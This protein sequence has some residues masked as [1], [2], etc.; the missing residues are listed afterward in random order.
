MNP[1][2]SDS[3]SA[4]AKLSTEQRVA[5]E[6][7]GQDV[8]VVAGPGS[9]KTRVLTER[10]AWLVEAREVN[11]ARILAITFTEK[12]AIEIKRR[13]VARFADRSEFRESIERAWVSTIDGFCARI[14]RENAIAAGLSPEF[15]I[16]EAA[17]AK[18]LQR[19]AGEEALD[20]LLQERPVEFRRLLEAL[21]LSTQD[22]GRQ[23]DLCASLL[24]VYETMRTSGGV[25][26]P[27]A[28]ASEDVWPAVRAM[29]GTILADATA[30]NT[31]N[32][33]AA[34]A[35]VRE[36]AQAMLGLSG[37]PVANRHFECLSLARGIN[38][39]HLMT[40]SPARESFKTLKDD[41]NPQLESQWISLRYADLHD[42]L[43][44]ALKRMD[45][46]YRARKRQQG[47]LD[48]GDL[49]EFTI[50]L[51]E[52]NESI[53]SEVAARFDQVLMDE[54]QDTNRT[55]WRLIK[56]L[57]NTDAK[58]YAVGDIN[59][60]IYG[61]RNADPEV[62]A[63]YRNQLRISGAVIDELA[64]NYRSRPEILSAVSAMLDGQAGIE[65]RAL[66]ARGTFHEA[67]GPFVERFVGRPPADAIGN[68]DSA[69][70]C[71]A[72][73]VAAR[74][75]EWVDAGSYAFSDM[76]VLV[77]TFGA[78]GPFE[79]AFDRAGI[80]YLISGGRGF[81]EA[82]ETKDI[83]ALLAVLV[84][85]LDEI[86]LYG[87]LRGPLVN[88]SDEAL[89]QMGR[90][91]WRKEFEARFGELRKLAGFIAPDR[92]IAKAL[93]E[94]GY[95][96]SLA[97]AAQATGGRSLA[98]VDK[99]LAWIRSEFYKR[100]RPLAELLVDLEVLRESESIPEAPPA[101]AGNVVRIMTIH[102]AKGLEFPVVFVVA[103]NKGSDPRSPIIFVSREHGLG[104]KWRHPIT[105]EGTS[106][107]I[108][109]LLRK[110]EKNR[111]D[112][113][114]NRLF[115]VACTR[116]MEHLVLSY[117][118]LK[119]ARNWQKLAAAHVPEVTV[120]E[121]VVAVAPILLPKKAAAASTDVVALKA[122][123]V[124]GQHDAAAP[125]TSVAMF[126]ACPRRYYLARYL[127]LED[128]VEA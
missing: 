26:F 86:P 71:E 88:L 100:P 37:A 106:D 83:L 42:L 25:H 79:Q 107:P 95:M 112:A 38:A 7:S 62:F 72:S 8:C 27:S 47:M 53:R 4:F 69:Q 70:D 63:E 48:F 99:L 30:C 21:D 45:A 104:A 22:N 14:L 20:Q 17:S 96:T 81:L 125:V 11:P 127:G 92:L 31:P 33:R 12:A 61:F 60:S 44:E 65:P 98:N 19:D 2:A 39:G 115:Y 6:R 101:E 32:Q 52:S 10:F 126:A 108:H 77:R 105:G 122:P 110:R 111:E 113:E 13:L 123:E 89:F 67:A 50:D 93:D 114:S 66:Q 118:E 109:A 68:E 34:T 87:V 91:G 40:R 102:S 18:Q 55:Q 59:Q 15:S 36:W 82:R 124:H 121:S 117:S 51:L 85:P 24:D 46:T 29:L 73:L 16:L 57:C 56:L 54:L 64:D 43:N 116:A 119:T 78:V 23:P 84:N 58:L 1:G 120:A 9:G 49:G 80:P 28:V 75:R 3:S 103:L 5:V 35:N 74:I 41:L 94:C 97:D 90:E 128:A 76:A